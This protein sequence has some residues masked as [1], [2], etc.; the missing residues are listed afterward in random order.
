M[1][2]F[3]FLYSV[4]N[5]PAITY[6]YHEKTTFIPLRAFRNQLFSASTKPGKN[7]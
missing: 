3:D 7:E 1:T 6:F 5:L 2:D 4:H